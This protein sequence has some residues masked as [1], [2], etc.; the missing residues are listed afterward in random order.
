MSDYSCTKGHELVLVDPDLPIRCR[1]D[2]CAGI[3]VEVQI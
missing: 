2:E 1:E 3:V